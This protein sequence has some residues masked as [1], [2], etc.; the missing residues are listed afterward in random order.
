[1]IAKSAARKPRYRAYHD[2]EVSEDKVGLGGPYKCLKFLSGPVVGRPITL[3]GPCQPPPESTKE[4]PFSRAE[5]VL[6][7]IGAQVL[8]IGFHGQ[9]VLR[10]RMIRNHCT[11]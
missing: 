2:V 8:S 5:A 3:G 1:M 11:L 4:V 9:I 10:L 7:G 6:A